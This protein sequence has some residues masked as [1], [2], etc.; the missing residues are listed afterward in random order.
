[1]GAF[2][3]VNNTKRGYEKAVGMYV[4]RFSRDTTLNRTQFS[5]KK[6]TIKAIYKALIYSV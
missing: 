3:C 4:K 1:M 6:K 5:P 2:D